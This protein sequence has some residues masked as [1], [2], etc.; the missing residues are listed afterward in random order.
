MTRTTFLLLMLG[1]MVAWCLAR[2]ADAWVAYRSYGAYGGAA[3]WGGAYHG[4]YVHPAPLYGS[5]GS[6][7]GRYGGSASWSHGSG[8]ATGAY[9]G[10]AS[11]GGGSGSVSGR[12]GG[13]ASWSR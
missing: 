1:L 7:T 13:S 6:A 2:P 5:S 9:G 3:A 8:S 10:S 12:Y 11:W 4:A